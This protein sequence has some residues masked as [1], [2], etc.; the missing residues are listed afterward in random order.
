IRSM[1]SFALI[2]SK[3]HEIRSLKQ[4]IILPRQHSQVDAAEWLNH[5]A[6]CADIEIASPR[7]NLR[8]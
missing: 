5:V 3:Q 1:R 2:T 8:F 6:L 4:V 7:E